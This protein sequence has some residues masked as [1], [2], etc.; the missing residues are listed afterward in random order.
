MA[1]PGMDITSFVGKLLEQDHVDALRGGSQGAR[2]GGDGDR[3]LLPDRRHPLRTQLRVDP[4]SDESE[5]RGSTGRSA[6]H[7][8]ASRTVS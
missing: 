5:T 3:G 7:G 8:A 1:T 2:P 6:I 4:L